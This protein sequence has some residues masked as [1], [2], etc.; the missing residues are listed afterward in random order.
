[1]AEMLYGIRAITS[2]PVSFTWV[3]VPF[4]SQQGVRPWSDMPTWIPGDPQ[5]LVSVARAVAAGLTFRPL[6]VT[7][8]DTLRDYQSR[9]EAE[10]TELRAGIAPERERE[11]LAAWHAKEEGNK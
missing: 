5:S 9:P 4:L 10:R 7:A 1:M 8:W 2:T 3:P 11:V 6:A